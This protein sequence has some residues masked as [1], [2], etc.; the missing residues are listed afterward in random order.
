MA[1][2]TFA[3]VDADTRTLRAA[4]TVPPPP[5]RLWLIDQMIRQLKQY[6][7]WQKLDVLWVLSAHDS[8]A[9]RL[10]WK[11][12]SSYTLTAVNSPT[13]TADRGYTGNGTTS[14]VNTGWAP[15]NGVNFTSTSAM[16]GIYVLSGADAASGSVTAMGGNDA[17][18]GRT[19]IR[20]YT[21]A[22]TMQGGITTN[23]TGTFSPLSPSSST[24]LGFT[25]FDRVSNTN[26]KIYRNGVLRLSPV[27]TNATLSSAAL[28]LGARNGNGTAS[29]FMASDNIFSLALCGGS[30]SEQQHAALYNISQTYLRAAGAA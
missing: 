23:G 3:A 17:G 29:E 24:R 12:P 9:A 15:N 14:Y 27:S 30:L 18:I 28:Y 22:D 20:P 16:F 7:I 11:N 19:Y 8:Q 2:D 26:I 21:A 4:M 6:G 13:F 1:F 10:N 5:G 25:L